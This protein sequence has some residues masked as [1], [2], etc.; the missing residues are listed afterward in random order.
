MSLTANTAAATPDPTKATGVT[1]PKGFA[2]TATTAG[3]KPSGN[4]DM[5]LILNQGPLD[6]AAAVFTRNRVQASPVRLT[7]AHLVDDTIKACIINSG[8]ANACNGPQGDK[9]ALHTA[10][11]VAQALGVAT[12]DIAVMSTG[13]IGDTLPMD[14]VLAGVETLTDGIGAPE[15]TTPAA[16][17]ASAD[18]IRTTDLVLKVASYQSKAGWTVGAMVKGVGMI[19]PSMATLLGVFTTDAVISAAEAKAV[20][21]PVS[22]ETFNRLDVDGATSTNDTVLLMASGASGVE[23]D[24]EEFAHAVRSVADDLVVQLQ[25]DAEG[26]TKRVAITVK[27]AANNDDAVVAARVV[28]RDNLFKCAMFGSDPNWGRVLAAVGMAPVDMQPERISVTFNGTP[29]CVNATGAEGARDVDL[30]GTDVHVEIDLG[31]GGSG[32]GTVR[33]TDLSHDYVHINSAYST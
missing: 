15:A 20:L 1:A 11:A 28:G 30:S 31:T 17:I 3:I 18:A 13:L 10:D 19:S 26:V 32:I 23:P 14:K 21:S 16:A 8:N 27:G 6:V 5:T 7:R 4:P 22:D 29:V 33:T 25:S 12:T 9:D 24:P 2:A